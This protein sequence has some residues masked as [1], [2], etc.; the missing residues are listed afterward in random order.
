MADVEG[1]VRKKGKK[2]KRDGAETLKIKGGP[3]RFLGKGFDV[4]QRWC[5]AQEFLI[6][7]GA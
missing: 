7:G 2:G 5:G 6:S 1:E 3:F 4:A